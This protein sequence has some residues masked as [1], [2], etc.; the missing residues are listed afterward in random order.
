MDYVEMF[1]IYRS[2]KV[3]EIHLQIQIGENKDGIQARARG[4]GV[5][6]LERSQKIL[7]KYGV[8]EIYIE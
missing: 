8:D 1:Q 2:K 3:Q 7:R 6:H 4:Q 5:A